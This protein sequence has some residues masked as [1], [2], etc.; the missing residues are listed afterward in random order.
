MDESTKSSEPTTLIPLGLPGLT[1][2]VFMG[3][4]KQISCF[5]GIFQFKTSLFEKT[6]R[7]C[8]TIDFQKMDIHCRMRSKISKFPKYYFY[9]R[10][11]GS[12]KR[13][14]YRR[15]KILAKY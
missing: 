10:R 9:W 12:N 2:V 1:K 11:R 4:D 6:M 8:E 5:A 7:T 15:L 14:H 3:D 13:W